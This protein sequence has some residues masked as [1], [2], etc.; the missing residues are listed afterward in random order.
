MTTSTRRHDLILV[1][2]S[3][4]SSFFLKKFLEKQAQ[5]RSTSQI[6]VLVLEKGPLHNHS[7]QLDHYRQMTSA[8][9]PLIINPNTDH[10]WVSN[11]LFGGNS[12]AWWACTPRMLPS[13]FELQGRYGVGMNWPI[14]Y[15]DLESY[16]TE[17]E[18]IM[19]VSGAAN[20]PYP[21]SQP[22]PQPPHRLNATDQLFQ[23][24]YPQHYFPQP[25]A[26]RRQ[27][28]N[29][30]PA[31]CANGVCTT[32]PINAKFTILNGLEYLYR[33]PGVELQLESD[34]LSLITEGNRVT[35]VLYRDN[36]GVEQ[37]ARGELIALGANALFNTQILMRSNMQHKVLGHYLNEQVSFNVIARLN[38]LDN[39]QGSTSITGHG[40]M[41]YD[42]EH[43]QQRAACLIEN[44]NIFQSLLRTEENRWT[45]AMLLRCI[46]E[47]IPQYDNYVTLPKNDP[48]RV[49]IHYSGHS[50]HAEKGIEFMRAKGIDDLLAGF[51]VE[52]Y[53]VKKLNKTEAHILGTHRMG[54]D[55]ANSIVDDKL[56]HHQYRNL[57]VLG[58]GTFPST[59]PA[60]PT[61]T[62]CALS[63]RAADQLF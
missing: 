24:K 15:Q 26:R 47:D 44:S 23:K 52:N 56:L 50:A 55:P 41:Y 9:N 27:A 49:E 17:A 61:L 63:L 10:Y 2:S 4:A 58:S 7:W 29:Q 54:S 40:Y 34:V 45:Q 5:R 59:A 38:G 33:H 48:S 39:F 22:F 1:G 3:F 18:N 57:L 42:G 11:I 43:R 36:A 28:V 31:C 25:T 53:E 19:S 21:I 13:D 62:I 35:G 32:C 46:F 30:T 14:R 8:E 6:S 12:N 60:N 20:P 16:Y 37:Q 51:P